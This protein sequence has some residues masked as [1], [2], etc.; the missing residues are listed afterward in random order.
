MFVRPGPAHHAGASQGLCVSLQL[1]TLWR[2]PHALADLSQGYQAAIDLRFGFLGA[3]GLW[4]ARGAG[5]L[6]TRRCRTTRARCGI[7]RP[8][9]FG[10][11]LLSPAHALD[12][13]VGGVHFVELFLG[14]PLFRVRT[15]VDHLA[16]N[17]FGPRRADR[18]DVL[19]F[20]V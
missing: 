8:N 16:R 5:R 9:S 11:S 20:L 1:P 3:G 13:L 18:G 14:R 10:A 7:D 19:A 6:L 2:F 12:V 15:S 4:V 17:P